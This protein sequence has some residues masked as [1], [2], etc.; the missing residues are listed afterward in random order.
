VKIRWTLAAAT[1]ARCF[2][3]DRD[4]MRAI[5]APS[6]AWPEAPAEGFHRGRYHRLRVDRYRIGALGFIGWR[7][8]V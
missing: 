4:G 3:P 6:Q 8:G 1:S 7:Q 2:L 5:G